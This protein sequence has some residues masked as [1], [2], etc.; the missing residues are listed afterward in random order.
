MDARFSNIPTAVM[1]ALSRLADAGYEAYIVG[2]CVRDILMGTSPSDYDITTSALPEETKAVFEGFR[3]IETGIA[4][5]T[6][7]VI[8]GGMPLEIT[9]YRVDSDYSD[10]RH[11]DRVEFTPS[12]S[13]DLAR[14][15]FTV[16]AMAYS[17]G[18][19]VVD[20]F[21]GQKDIESGII[22]CV[23]DPELRFSEDSL[24]IMRAL[25]FAA[26]LGFG[27]DENTGA[28]MRALAS[29][30]GRV[31][32]E[33][34]YTEL[35]KLLLGKNVRSVLT[36]YADV[37]SAVIPELGLMIGF[38][39][40]NPHHIYDV[41][42]HTAAVVENT[43]AEADLRLAALLHDIG[44]PR[45][46]TMDED[47]VGHFIGHEKLGAQMAEDIM[48]RLKADSETKNRVVLLVAH[49]FDLI[50]PSKKAVKRALS[51]LT[52]E[53]FF[54]L[55]ALIRADNLALAPEYRDR[56]S[57]IDTLESIAKEIIAEGECFSI[58]DLAVDGNDLTA[59]GIPPSRRLGEILKALLESVMDGK[60]ENERSA[61]LKAAQDIQTEMNK[62]QRGNGI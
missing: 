21:G 61:L 23:G 16:N 57:G 34:I 32:A 55:T 3:L 22:R 47:G 60:T 46:F 26:T 8:V 43:P 25:R 13:E 6:V 10:G 33:R 39:Q 11:P 56:A 15:D 42:E 48:T 54:E 51:K 50:H 29:K 2:G 40:H 7:T 31:S 44:K 52:P 9:T 27:I 28:G 30:M 49:H 35:V 19:G 36:E 41:M 38:D 5:G 53:M 14:R 4:H 17:H 37:L 18:S 45:C 62:E 20:L 24:R 58:K 1:T 59:I 12:L